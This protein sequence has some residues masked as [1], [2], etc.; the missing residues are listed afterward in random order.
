MLPT[1]DTAVRAALHR[2]KLQHLK[3]MPNTIVVDELGLAHARSRVDVAVINGCVHGYEIKSGQ[4]TLDRLPGQI[5]IYRETLEKLTIVCASKHIE[6]VEMLV[7]EWCGILEARQ[8]QRGAIHFSS[9][10]RDRTNPDMNPVMLAHLLWRPEAIELLSRFGLPARDLRRPRKQLYE[11][12]AQV[13]SAKEITASIRE[14]MGARRAWRDP[15]VH[16]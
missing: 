9:V 16:V 12:L 5:K 15:P 13:L 4:D 1:N 3:A 2:K 10:R 6:R 11:L 8:G 7:P 14:F